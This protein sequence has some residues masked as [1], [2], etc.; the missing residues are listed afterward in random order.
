MRR[1]IFTILSIC[2][3]GT[4]G[5]GCA[6]RRPMRVY[7]PHALARETFTR[8]P[9]QLVMVNPLVRRLRRRIQHAPPALARQRAWW[10]T[11][12]HA[13]LNV[14]PGL[15]VHALAGYVIRIDDDQRSFGGNIFN[16]YRR[17]F[18]SARYGRTRR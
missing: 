13:Y 14:R 4:I 3:A 9:T 1:P 12:N 15:P 18:H 6:T 17:S 5:G 7:D 11:R 2:L 10:L 8:H 16:S